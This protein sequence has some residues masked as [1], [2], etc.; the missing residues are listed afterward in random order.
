MQFSLNI[1]EKKWIR[2]PSV[3]WSVWQAAFVWPAFDGRV[4]HNLIYFTII[5]G[6]EK[7]L[8]E[9][10]V[11]RHNKAACGPTMSVMKD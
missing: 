9:K 3:G 8:P 6:L 5:L 2:G 1:A 10:L 11:I 4:T 7:H